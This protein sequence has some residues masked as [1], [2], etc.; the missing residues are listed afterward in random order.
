MKT[1]KKVLATAMLA[2]AMSF[3]P[4]H[5]EEGADANTGLVFSGDSEKFITYEQNSAYEN[6]M[7][8]EKRVQQIT[9][10]NEDYREMKFYVR[11]EYTNPLGEGVSNEQI[12]YD[13]E[14]S[15]NGEVFYSGKLGGMT[16]ANMNSLEQNYLLKTLKKGE[17]TTVDL[18]IRIDGDS[19]D[20]TY[21]NTEGYLNLI[22][23]VE[24]EDN[25]PVEKVVTV[26]KK[27]PVINKIPGVQT[28]DTTVIGTIL[29][30]F[31]A[32]LALII[33][34]IVMKIRNRKGE[35]NEKV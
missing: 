14:F 3:V 18:I 13:I 4:I 31:V 27:V 5:A 24:H 20:N 32:S 15:N 8:G 2:L 33:V 10:K 21:Q 17:T 6:M 23:S 35:R 34:I 12:A 26:I 30:M 7:P 29:G 28:G 25:T 22:F 11:G 19:M 9:L 1:Y 16:K